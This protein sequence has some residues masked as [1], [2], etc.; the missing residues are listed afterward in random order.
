MKLVALTA[1]L[2][3]SA[4]ALPAPSASNIAGQSTTVLHAA[5]IVDPVTGRASGPV[6]IRVRDGKIAEL[7]ESP[8]APTGAIDL[9]TLTVLPGLIDAHV[10]LQIG[11]TVEANALAAVLLGD[12]GGGA[13]VSLVRQRIEAN[14]EAGETQERG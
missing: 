13:S 6:N 14:Q 9:G 7:I 4:A 3:V 5:R 1:A 10:H 11:G 12:Q 2:L 8:S